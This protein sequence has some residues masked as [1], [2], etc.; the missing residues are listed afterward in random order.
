[1][2]GLL[3]SVVL[4]GCAIGLMVVLTGIFAVALIAM[5]RLETRRS[6]AEVEDLAGRTGLRPGKHGNEVGRLIEDLLADPAGVDEAGAPRPSGQP[7]RAMRTRSLASSR[8]PPDAAC[9]L[10]A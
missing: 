4:I 3:A 6:Q 2:S 1:M 7:Q 8:W 10:I 5:D 9:S